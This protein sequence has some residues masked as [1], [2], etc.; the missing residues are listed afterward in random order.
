[1]TLTAQVLLPLPLP[2]FSFLVP[3][4]SRAGP[5]GGRV[6]VP[7]QGSLRVG[8]CTG[9]TDAG[10]GAGLD[11]R[12]LVCWL[13]DDPFFADGA[14]ELFS[15]LAAI[16][17]AP[18]GLILEAFAFSGFQPDLVHEIRLG[19]PSELAPD[20]VAGEWQ[21]AGIVPLEVL[22]RLRQEGLVDERAREAQRLVSR[23]TAVAD[24]PDA[25]GSDAR[26][27]N[28]RTAL[29]QLLR[30]PAESAAALARTA[31]VPVSSV[32]TLINR[33]L[34]RFEDVPAPAPRLPEPD[35]S[36]PL[37]P[38]SLSLPA[39][40]PFSLTGGLRRDRLA[41]LAPLLRDELAAGR[42][43]L[44]LVPELAVLT[45][46][47]AL[48]A[49][50]FPVLQVSGEL[51]D[52]ARAHTVQLAATAEKPVVIVGTWP[53][54]LLRTSSPGCIVVL[55]SASPSFKLLSGARLFVPEAARR[56]AAVTDRRLIETEVTGNA[57][58]N[59]VY[60][61]RLQL[62]LIGQRLH[63]T[64]LTDASSW[65]LDADLVRVL[66]QVQERG[67]QALLLSSRR[68]FSGALS[69]HDCGTPV[70]C[71]N[72][73]L[74]LRYHQSGPLLRCHQCNHERSVPPRCP[75]CGS[76]QLEPNRAAGT[77]WL[78]SGVRR[79]LPGFPVLRYDSDVR[80]DPAA[81][82]AGEPGVL[83]AT[84][85]A[86]R[87]P[88]LPNVS[89]I[90]VT[91]FDAHLSLS[92]FRAGEATLRLMLQLPELTER[93]RPLVLIQTFQPDHPV[94]R[95]LLADDRDKALEDFTSSTLERRQAFGYPPFA[96]LAR[97]EISARDRAA[98]ERE[99]IRLRGALLA[100]GASDSEVLG[101]TPAGVAR[102]R[103]R[104]VWQLVLRSSDPGRFSEMLQGV[105]AGQ[106][107]ARFRVDVDPREVSLQLE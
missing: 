5:V 18:P 94:L 89:L 92:D 4:G 77:Q 64:D 73:D 53:A 2:A 104:Y 69:C 90:A 23:L 62:P 95:T 83:V 66:R 78:A 60:A 67:R 41:E 72:C 99:A 12:E 55:E 57:E 105:P 25:A 19:Q 71:P 39:E 38:A 82:Y 11:L 52:A 37:R 75:E 21:P 24:D 81:L 30:G 34:A 15:E 96:Q 56:L 33:G 27:A 44:V 3:P 61:T 58:L 68:G 51:D 47:A 50:S 76:E 97:V 1:M 79:L 98:A 84:T 93:G 46:T 101:P 49:A 8:L 63:V 29:A 54:L 22:E 16:T 48:L 32:R 70:P 91:L 74:P 10:S 87:L 6:V 31:G 28:Q 35:P 13:D 107:G 36:P 65:P 17:A 88:P 7:W 86:L 26:R 45:E 20:L 103:G 43:P 40:G 42:S 106:Q 14:T 59:A 9:L 102:V 80:E 100:A 85:A